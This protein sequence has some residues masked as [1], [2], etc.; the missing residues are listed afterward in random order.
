MGLNCGT[1][2]VPLTSG[3]SSNEGSAENSPTKTPKASISRIDVELSG[4]SI[5]RNRCR[6]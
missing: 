5:M 3:G 2:L 6:A 1:P 4:E